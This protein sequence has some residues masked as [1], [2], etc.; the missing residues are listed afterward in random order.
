M[1]KR[2][3]LLMLLMSFQFVQAQVTFP[4][5]G[6]EDKRPQLYA[7]INATIHIDYATVIENAVMIVQN[8]KIVGVGADLA[9]PKGAIV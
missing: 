7:F 1:L 4:T 5:N 9:I 3:L 2:L 8:D 6:V